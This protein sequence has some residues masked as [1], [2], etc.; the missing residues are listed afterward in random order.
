MDMGAPGLQSWLSWSQREKFISFRSFRI[1]LTICRQIMFKLFHDTA[2]YPLMLLF[3]VLLCV[4]LLWD[5]KSMGAAFP[6]QQEARDKSWR[7]QM[8][9]RGR[10]K[11]H[12]GGKWMSWSGLWRIVSRGRDPMLKQGKNVRSPPTVDKRAAET[13]RDELITTCIPHTCQDIFCRSF[14]MDYFSWVSGGPVLQ[15]LTSAQCLWHTDSSA[16]RNMTAC[17]GKSFS[18][19]SVRFLSGNR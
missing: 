9:E 3:N 7:R 10:K 6:L 15:T 16:G 4:L 17:V 11:A 13:M 1:L 19:P 12:F 18:I 14:W 2:T 8:Q 5:T